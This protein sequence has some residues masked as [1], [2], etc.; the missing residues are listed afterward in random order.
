MS[1]AGAAPERRD[2]GAAPPKA[3]SKSGTGAFS[4]Y[5]G[6]CGGGGKEL[7]NASARLGGGGGGCNWTADWCEREKSSKSRDCSAGDS[8]SCCRGPSR[9]D[10][11]CA[12]GVA[13]EGSSAFVRAVRGFD[14]EAVG[15]HAVVARSRRDIFVACRD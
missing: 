6:T 12:L 3:A 8:S 14:E 10:C 15:S 13:E 5:A 1:G 7:R 2:A 4:M 11:A 9:S